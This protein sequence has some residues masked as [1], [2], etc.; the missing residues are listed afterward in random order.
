MMIM[1]ICRT[2]NGLVK[3]ISKKE[4]CVLKIWG[5]DGIQS[6]TMNINLGEGRYSMVSKKTFNIVK[7]NLVFLPTGEYTKDMKRFAYFY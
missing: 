7:N 4:N 5:I 6:E 1:K 3:A 2:V